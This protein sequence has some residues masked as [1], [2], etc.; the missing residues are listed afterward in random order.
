MALR[1]ID[2]AT[3]FSEIVNVADDYGVT[4]MAL[5]SAL[6]DLVGGPAGFPVDARARRAALEHWGSS[7]T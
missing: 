2:S 6:I 7:L 1:R 4:L 3:A 5:A